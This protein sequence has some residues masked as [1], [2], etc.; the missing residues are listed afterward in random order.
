M[1]TAEHWDLM[2]RAC[3]AKFTQCE[4]ARTALLS[5]R[6]RP[7]THKMRRD[8][9]SIPGIVMAEIWMQIR[10]GIRSSRGGES[11]EIA[12]IVDEVARR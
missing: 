10:N 12:P 8:S 6:E 2:R 3:W 9:R 4:A 11:P 1:G 7:L 5:T